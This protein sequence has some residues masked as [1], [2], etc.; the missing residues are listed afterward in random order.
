MDVWDML[1]HG[2]MTPMDW[3]EII[4]QRIKEGRCRKC[5]AFDGPTHRCP[6][7]SKVTPDTTEEI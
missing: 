5:G 6:S 2:Y 7:I 4:Q 1:D 3:Y